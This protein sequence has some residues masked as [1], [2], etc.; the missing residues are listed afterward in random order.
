MVRPS[1]RDLAMTRLG[2]VGDPH[3]EFFEHDV[4]LRQHVFILQDQAGHA[5]GLE[6]H[7]F[8]QL[9]ARHPLEIA[10]I[11]GRREGVLVAADPKHG[12]GKLTGRMLAG[13]LEHQMFEKVREARFAGRLVG[14]ADLVPDH[15]RD[16]RSAVIRDHQNLQAV[17]EGKGGGWLGGHR[18]LGEGAACG[19]SERQ[20]QRNEERDG[21]AV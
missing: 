13:A 5:I 7:H 6:L 18:G 12:L 10:G 4:A 20:G 2:V 1:A 14:G 9:L 3:V 19:D 16:D 15:L 8:G 11:V 21:E 17:A